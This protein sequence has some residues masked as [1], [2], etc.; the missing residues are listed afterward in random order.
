MSATS[1]ERKV[2]GVLTEHEPVGHEFI[3]QLWDDETLSNNCRMHGFPVWNK[4]LGLLH[5]NLVIH[6][7]GVQMIEELF[8][9]FLSYDYNFERK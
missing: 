8:T 4:L 7:G 1:I 6:K 5:R 2:N 3:L 9:K